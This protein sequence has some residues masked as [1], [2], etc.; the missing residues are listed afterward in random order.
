M[1]L[2]WFFLFLCCVWPL[3]HSFQEEHL[4]IQFIYRVVNLRP[5]C[6]VLMITSKTKEDLQRLLLQQMT[7]IVV[8]MI[9]L[10]SEEVILDYEKN[11]Q[12][13]FYIFS[14]PFIIAQDNGKGGQRR[15]GHF[16]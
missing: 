3:A 9:V 15:F 6:T 2:S 13:D 4:I 7:T 10:D 5:E 11:I 12:I 14:Y 8:P 1:S 16:P